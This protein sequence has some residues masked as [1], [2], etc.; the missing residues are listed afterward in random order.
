MSSVVSS[1][2][3]LAIDPTF[4]LM[5][6]IKDDGSNTRSDITTMDRNLTGLGNLNTTAILQ[7]SDRKTLHDNQVADNRFREN[8]QDANRNT[9]SILSDADRKHIHDNQVADNRFREGRQDGLRNTDNIMQAAER[10]ILHDNIVSDNRF[11]EN[12]ENTNRAYDNSIVDGRRNMEFL[13][14]AV[15]RNG[16]T[17]L[18]DS[19][20]NMDNLSAAIERNGT[21]NSATTQSTSTATQLAVERNGTTNE[22]STERNAGLIRDLINQQA[23]EERMNSA[24]TRADIMSG[25]KDTLLAAKDSDIRVGDV[26]RTTE[27]LINATSY[28]VLK[29][30]KD[31]ETVLAHNAADAARDAANAMRDALTN[32]SEIMRQA[33]QLANANTRDVLGMRADIL[34]QASDNTAAIQ[35]EAL[36]NKD[37]LAN[38]MDYQ[39]DNLKQKIADSALLQRD[40]DGSRL[41]DNSNDYRIENAILK[42]RHHHGYE[43]HHGH[44]HSDGHIHNNLY[45]GHGYPPHHH[46][47]FRGGEGGGFGGQ[48]GFAGQGAFGGPGSFG[49]NGIQSQSNSN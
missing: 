23:R 34:R 6:A 8:R 12:R 18:T 39:Y 35:I 31:L 25:I 29:T 42:E 41:R 44:R 3:P 14:G 24:Q 36:K 2:T 4:L 7:D 38:K 10:H 9:D 28:N 30:Q 45:S 16:I 27:G 20:R 1:P 46:E 15:E 19:R 33:E 22:V 47:R 26:L 5:N 43:G 11:R 13:S 40:I 37:H 21:T 48:G 49:P 32:R 17:N